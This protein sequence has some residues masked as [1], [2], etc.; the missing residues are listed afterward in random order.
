MESTNLMYILRKVKQKKRL[1]I[2]KLRAAFTSTLT[3]NYNQDS[4]RFFKGKGTKKGRANPLFLHLS[5][6]THNGTWE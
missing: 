4:P 6:V 2:N 3:N 5:S 1:K